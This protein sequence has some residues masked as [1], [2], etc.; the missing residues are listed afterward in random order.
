MLRKFAKIAELVRAE[1]ESD[2]QNHAEYIR[3]ADDSRL[4]SYSTDTRYMQYKNGT[5][6][7]EKCVEYALQRNEKKYN[8]EL[9]KELERLENMENAPEIT[10]ISIDVDWRRN[11]TWGYNPFATVR[12]WTTNGYFEATGYASGCG[13]DKRSAAVGA[14]LNKIPAVIAAVCALKENNMTEERT[15]SNECCG[16]GAGYGAIPYFEGGVGINC[17]IS[18]LEKCGLKKTAEHG[19]KTTD[20]YRF[21]KA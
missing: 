2:K 9:A 13:Y 12:V 17:H 18:I 4:A 14:A 21:E 10:D 16:Y 15:K 20:Y 7:R 6:T 5:I 3:T 8:K 11:P 19:T 1:Y